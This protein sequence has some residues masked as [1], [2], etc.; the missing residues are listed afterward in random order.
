MAVAFRI[1]SHEMPEDA[2]KIKDP[3]HD[4]DS[5]WAFYK[6]SFWHRGVGQTKWTRVKRISMT[7]KRLVALHTIMQIAEEQDNG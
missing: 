4:G 7:P 2:P 3:H 5:T 1:K 6:N